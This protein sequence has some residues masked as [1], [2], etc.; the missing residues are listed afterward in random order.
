MKWSIICLTFFVIPATPCDAKFP[1]LGDQS[2]TRQSERTPKETP[3]VEE[4]VTPLI[5]TWSGTMTVDGKE[6]K[7][8]ELQVQK[9]TPCGMCRIQALRFDFQFDDANY[10][11]PVPPIFT[12]WAPNAGNLGV[13]SFFVNFRLHGGVKICGTME[14]VFSN[15]K[16]TDDGIACDIAYIHDSSHGF[17]ETE[18]VV[19]SSYTLSKQGKEIRGSVSTPKKVTFSFARVGRAD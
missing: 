6:L 3:T 1:V 19:T 10:Q 14:L 12:L 13:N 17:T 7:V 16:R 8:N 5:G 2:P 4:A 9:F 11:L 18:S 15:P